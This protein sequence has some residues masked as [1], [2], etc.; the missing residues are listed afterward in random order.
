MIYIQEAQQTASRKK[1]KGTKYE[2]HS[3]QITAEVWDWE[4]SE[5]ERTQR[6]Q[7]G[8]LASP[9]KPWR[10]DAVGAV[11]KALKEEEPLAK[12][13]VSGKTGFQKGR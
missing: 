6:G 8:L 7:G 2:T 4:S 9:W 13:P 10:L 11:C 3:R 1:C 12:N 5:G